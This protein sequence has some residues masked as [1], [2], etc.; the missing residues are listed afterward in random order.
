MEGPT[1]NHMTTK[2]SICRAKNWT[3]ESLMPKMGRGVEEIG[4]QSLKNKSFLMLPSGKHENNVYI[5]HVALD[6]AEGTAKKLRRN[7]STAV[8]RVDGKFLEDKG[9][10]D[11]ID[12]MR[13][14]SKKR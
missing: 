7:T 14:I 10:S 11:K 6:V 8:T 13:N 4:M 5:L 9:F 2:A 3:T 1:L 12:Q